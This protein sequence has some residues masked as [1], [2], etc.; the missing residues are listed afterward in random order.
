MRALPRSGRW[1]CA[2]LLA[3]VSLGEFCE[4]N[5]LVAGPGPAAIRQSVGTSRAR[6]L[7]NKVEA[8]RDRAVA[9]A[10]SPTGKFLAVGLESGHLA[11]WNLT[12]KKLQFTQQAH[13]QTGQ[14]ALVRRRR[15]ANADRR[16]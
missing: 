14:A 8:S 2:C 3:I 15:S 11:V 12:T 6:R 10:F 13:E 9:V 16:R 1:V 5:R 7:R 4:W